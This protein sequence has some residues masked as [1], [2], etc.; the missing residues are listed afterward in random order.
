L[1]LIRKKDVGNMREESG[2][3]GPAVVAAT[4]KRN[5]KYKFGLKNYF[6]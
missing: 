2:F 4:F 6:V 1:L 3:W 5:I